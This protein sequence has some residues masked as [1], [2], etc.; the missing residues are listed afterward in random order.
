MQSYISFIL[1]SLAGIR[2]R[3]AP[4]ALL[5]ASS[6]LAAENENPALIFNAACFQFDTQFHFPVKY[7][8]GAET[9]PC[10]SPTEPRWFALERE[11]LLCASK[12]LDI[13]PH[14]LLL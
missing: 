10:D 11:P 1:F 13:V 4:L 6:S 7:G 8:P 12:Q 9:S 3:F 2:R 14:Y 5:P